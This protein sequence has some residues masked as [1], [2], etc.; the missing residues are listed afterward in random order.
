M[1]TSS[2]SS[3]LRITGMNSGLDT[4]S[5]VES[6]M[7]IEQLKVDRVFRQKTTM[8]WELEARQNISSSISTFRQ[9]N[10]SALSSTNL[11]SSTAFNTFKVSLSAESSSVAVKATTDAMVG[12]ST[13]NSITRIAAASSTSSTAGVSNGTPLSRSSTLADLS[14][15]TA[16]Q[17]GGDNSDEI[18]FSIN[19]EAFTFK[20]TDTL[21]TMIDTINSSDADVTISYSELSDKFTVK[22]NVT[23]AASSINITNTTGNAFGAGS[24]FGIAA[25]D[26]TNGQDAMLTINGYTVT[27]SENNFTIDGINYTLKAPTATA[28]DFTV[29]RDVDTVVD[30]I[31]NFVSQYNDLIDK[32]QSA[33][34][35]TADNDYYPLTAKE[36]GDMSEDEI[37]TWE[38]KAK[39]GL[40]HNDRN[41]SSLLTSLRRIL[42]ETV[43]GTGLS[44]SSIGLRTGSYK[45]GG[46]ISIDEDDLR[47]ALNRM[48]DKVTDLFTQS[49]SAG[50]GAGF[51]STLSSAL[52]NYSKSYNE[53]LAKQDI[54]KITTRINT[55][56]EQLVDKEN[57][58]Y[59]KYAAM[60]ST[61]ASLN[62]QS[63]W[64]SSQFSGN[65]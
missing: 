4:D 19:S 50:N 30:R 49:A 35:E 8:E 16:L 18:S 14:L 46:K 44:L 9:T 7:Q 17:F 55:L 60:E 56:E 21:R 15:S 3:M 23:G 62:S 32:L 54:S 25:G 11:Y 48:P 61:L 5:I 29:E 65:L 27:R 12:T 28:V 20:N 47:D 59:N 24:A 2:I 34:K 6:L 52:T 36:K 45:D 58:L 42:Y 22:S 1:S 10:M 63:A 13:I 40:L 53:T 43:E 37:A 31:K 26:Y 39:A 64:L 41:T 33:V 38:T 57:T 51:L